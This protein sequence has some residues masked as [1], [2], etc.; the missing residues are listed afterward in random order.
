MFERILPGNRWM[1][2]THKD[3]G[4]GPSLTHN[5]GCSI[6][7]PVIRGKRTGNSND[8]RLKGA[9]HIADTIPAGTIMNDIGEKWIHL[10]FAQGHLR[11]VRTRNNIRIAM[12]AQ[13]I[14]KL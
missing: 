5:F 13:A 3:P 9:D 8:I 10:N 2:S 12:P 6:G 14:K 4:R 7:L 1:C 11:K